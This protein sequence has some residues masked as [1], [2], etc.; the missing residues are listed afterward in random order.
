MELKPDPRRTRKRKKIN[1]RKRHIVVDSMGLPLV[2]VVTAAS[3]QDRDGGFRLLAAL[4]ERLSTTSLVWADGGYARRLVDWA[5]SV[6]ALTVQDIKRADDTSGFKVLP[7]RWVIERTFGWMVALPA[8]GPRLR[9]PPR[10]PR[11]HGA[12]VQRHDHDPKTPTRD[13]GCSARSP[14]GTPPLRPATVQPEGRMNVYEQA[15][16][17]SG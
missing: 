1:G 17:L 13:I 9:T 14:M 8:A 16:G 5:R 3:M 6:L 7:R 10:P 11:S 15:L 12:L 2:V 4:R